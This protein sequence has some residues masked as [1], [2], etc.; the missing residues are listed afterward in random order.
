MPRTVG[1]LS[2]MP[3]LPPPMENRAVTGCS[4]CKYGTDTLAAGVAGK[5]RPRACNPL[6]CEA[7]HPLWRPKVVLS[8]SMSVSAWGV[9]MIFS[10]GKQNKYRER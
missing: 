5:K 2:L 4:V 8:A 1:L 3:G 6:A 9:V 10:S 7:R